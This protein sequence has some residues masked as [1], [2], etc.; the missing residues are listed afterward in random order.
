MYWAKAKTALYAPDTWNTV[1]LIAMGGMSH[2]ACCLPPLRHIALIC[3]CVCMYILC[4]IYPFACPTHNV[5][6][7]QSA[8]FLCPASPPR[9][10][11]AI[12]ACFKTAK[13]F[14]VYLF[15]LDHLFFISF[16]QLFCYWQTNHR[17]GIDLLWC[18]YE[19]LG[20]CVVSSQCNPV[21][22]TVPMVAVCTTHTNYD[23]A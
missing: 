9:T 13:N 18:V 21:L 6:A 16:I 23:V 4:I 19:V 22:V 1:L 2:A 10:Q 11:R 3:V 5:L 17:F 12:S 14:R 7:K 8:D 15:L 20:C